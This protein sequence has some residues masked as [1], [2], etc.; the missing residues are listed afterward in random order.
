MLNF[1]FLLYLPIFLFQIRVGSFY[2][3][4]SY[5]NFKF[6]QLFIN[7]LHFGQ[8]LNDPYNA[9]QIN[10]HL[11]NYDNFREID[12]GLFHGVPRHLVYFKNLLSFL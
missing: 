11:K 2:H 4:D 10:L 3:L 5:C 7:L 8:T 12:Q 6:L 1:Y 9:I